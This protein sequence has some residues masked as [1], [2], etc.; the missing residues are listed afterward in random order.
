M[1]LA[2]ATAA[3]VIQLLAEAAGRIQP[4]VG[5]LFSALKASWCAVLLAKACVWC[6]RGT[7]R[8]LPLPLHSCSQQPA[9]CC[10][11]PPLAGP[12]DGQQPQPGGQGAAAAG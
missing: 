1:R 11:S 10:G 8:T 9:R 5:E 3:Q 7:G 4:N 12:H 2:C 6:M